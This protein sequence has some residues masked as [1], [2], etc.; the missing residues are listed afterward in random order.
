VEGQA[1]RIRNFLR[2]GV[3]LDETGPSGLT[4][5]HRAVQSGHQNV[6]DILIGAG[7]DV[8]AMSEDFGTHL[9]LAA[10]RGAHDVVALLL[11]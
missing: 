2:M 3:D 6:V 10:L 11:R 9:C 1:P 5:L 7:A 8:N 4:V